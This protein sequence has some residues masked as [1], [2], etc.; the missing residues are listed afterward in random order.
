MCRFCWMDCAWGHSWVIAEMPCVHRCLLCDW[1][2]DRHLGN[3][4]DI[5]SDRVGSGKYGSPVVFRGEARGL[6]LAVSVRS[7]TRLSHQP[8]YLTVTFFFWP[9]LPTDSRPF[10]ALR[11][12]FVCRSTGSSSPSMGAFPLPAR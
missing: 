11:R 10:A 2:R 5:H 1:Q 12:G 4:R 9:C 6:S 7:R 3:N 8:T